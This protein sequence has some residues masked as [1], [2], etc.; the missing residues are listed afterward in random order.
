M[1]GTSTPIFSEQFG[2]SQFDSTKTRR[3]KG[4][5]YSAPQSHRYVAKF[6]KRED[7]EQK[8]P[9]ITSHYYWAYAQLLTSSVL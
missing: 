8:S 5:G 3:N 2:S 1:L 6:C 7:K 9:S 4:T